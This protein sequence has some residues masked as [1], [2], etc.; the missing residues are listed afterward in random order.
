MTRNVDVEHQ[1]QL[2]ASRLAAKGLLQSGDMMSMR[3]PDE[4]ATVSVHTDGSFSRSEIEASGTTHARIYAA[5]SDIGAVLQFDLIW[6]RAMHEMRATMPSVFDEQM[7]RLGRSVPCLGISS[8]D[9]LLIPAIAGQNNAFVC[10]D[11]TFCFGTGLERLLLNAELLEK[12]AK[13]FVLARASGQPV[14]EIPI[15][16]QDMAAGRLKNEEDAAAAR[17]RQ[18]LYSILTKGY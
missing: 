2:A 8:D 17:H 9:D 10:N 1:L 13:A 18:G 7:I 14:H 5:R 4:N 15:A 12:C 16:E 11:T 3:V 6:T